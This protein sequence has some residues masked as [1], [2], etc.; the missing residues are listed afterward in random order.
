M[1]SLLD[2][3]DSGEHILQITAAHVK[4]IR[5]LKFFP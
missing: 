4:Q 5:L 2:P 3:V 1:A